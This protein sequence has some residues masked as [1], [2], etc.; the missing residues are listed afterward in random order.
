MRGMADECLEVIGVE[1]S[2]EAI[3]RHFGARSDTGILDGWL[4]H[5]SDEADVPG[6]EVRSVPLLMTDPAATAAMVRA[7][8]DLAGVPA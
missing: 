1:T 6:V 2:A 3:G 8:L 5:S 4:I 7:A